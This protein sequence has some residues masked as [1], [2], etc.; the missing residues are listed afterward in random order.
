MANNK[1]LVPIEQNPIQ[2]SY[3]ADPDFGYGY[4]FEGSGGG[5]ESQKKQIF[6]FFAILRKHWMIIVGTML[7]VTVLTIIYEARKPDYYNAVSRIQV[8]SETES[9]GSGAVSSVVVNQTSDPTY[10]TTQL[11]ILE[12]TGL[13]RRV[14]KSL[15][16]EN[17]ETFRNPRTRRT[18]PLRGGTCLG[19][20]AFRRRSKKPIRQVMRMQ[21]KIS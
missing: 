16:L 18:K 4:E 21:I 9:P 14:V 17:N 11:Q 2:G 10:F 3:S 1:T 6:K 15:D 8:N 19:Y 7:L 12:G 13:L 20:L 5:G